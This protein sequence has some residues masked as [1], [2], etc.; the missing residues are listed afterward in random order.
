[1]PCTSFRVLILDDDPHTADLTR[2]LIEARGCGVAC[3]DDAERALAACSERPPHLILL[4]TGVSGIDGFRLIHAF[5]Q[6]CPD[7]LIVLTAAAA[8]IEL[9]VEAM[10]V[11]AFDVLPKPIEALRLTSV[12]DRALEER[13]RRQPAGGLAG[14]P[15]GLPGFEGM[16][17]ISPAMQAVY[18]LIEQ[19]AAT[20]ASVMILGETGTGKEMVA[21][22]IH[23]RSLRRLDLFHAVN[24]AAIPRE[25]AESI[26]FGHE[27]GAFTSA[28]R[29]RAGICEEAHGGTLFLDEIGELPID[30]QPKLLRFL[31]ERRFRRVGSLRELVSDARIISATNR[32]PYGEVQAG[33]LRADLFYRLNVVPIHLPPLRQRREDIPL[34]AR[35]ALRESAQRHGKRFVSIDESAMRLLIDHDW[36]GNVRQLFHVIERAVVLHEGE[37]V[38]SSMLIAD[39]GLLAHAAQ[40][41]RMDVVSPPAPALEVKIV[42]LMELERRAIEHAVTLCKGSAAEAARRLGISQATIYRKLKT[43]GLLARTPSVA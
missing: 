21:Q 34:L 6:R 26:L 10:R 1:M 37:Q 31:Q 29:A 20:D 12:L 2:L 23:R 16:V 7:V 25:L 14:G 18:R 27:K 30:L 32:D 3:Y 42:P 17:G 39:N 11:G 28:D 9:A 40:E 4:G 19:V 22:A 8:S 35:H 24:M 36:P 5:R 41:S 38:V 13:R 15:G 33:R 43:Y